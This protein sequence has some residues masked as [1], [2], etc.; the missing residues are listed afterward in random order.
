V[1]STT[2]LQVAINQADVVSAA[3]T[4]DAAAA[5]RQRLLEGPILGTILRLAA[6]T[7]VGSLAQ[8]IAGIVQMHFVGL[9]GV[10]ALAGVT[11]VFPC[12][13]LMQLVASGGIGAGVASA[14]A[15]SLGAGRKADAEALLLNAVFLAIIFGIAFTA[16]ELLLGP[17]LYRLLGGTGS[18][19][20]AS[21]DYS[22]R[23][24][25]V[26]IFVWLLSLLISAL[27]GCGNTTIPQIVAV[28]ALVIVVPLSPMLMFGWGPM[29]PL[30]VAGAGLA[31]ACYYLI[32]AAAL[33]CYFR[34]RHAPLRLSLDIRLI[35]R[36]HLRD[37]LKVGGLSS[38]SA[39]IPTLNVTLITAAIA[40]FGTE[41]VA[42][43][44]LA[45][46]A[47]YLLLPLYIGICVGVL[48]MVG[49]S[50]G[51]AQFRRARQIAWTGALVAGS[52][53]AIAALFLAL[54][55]SAWV[56]LFNHDPAVVASS[57]LYFR[58]VGIQFPL[59]A[60]AV[61]L[62]A[63]AQ[64]AGRPFWPFVAVITRLIIAAG[65]SWLVVAGMDGSIL[66]LYAVL[67]MGGICYCGVMIA[68]HL[69]GRIIPP[70]LPDPS[71]RATDRLASAGR[72]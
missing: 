5:R 23:V 16:V 1:A 66:V 36:R 49:V 28:L 62:G 50:V 68:A 19:L 3:P 69:S 31:F 12:L 2:G 46:R 51:A 55:P 67:A 4:I 45:V 20:A 54:V 71:E 10:D 14:I 22:N 37:I 38:L 15:R 35:E 70:P 72:S 39:A 17:I 25:A 48:P 21:L 58:I 57:S 53:G 47:D 64:G 32:G 8:I 11:L 6:P 7:L 27:V 60:A 13:T 18:V 59:S 65:G 42:G 52:I 26:S 9:L 34:S 63:A 30:G 56:G 29:P 44:G 24:F 41:T 61:V 33:L 40:R 43:Y